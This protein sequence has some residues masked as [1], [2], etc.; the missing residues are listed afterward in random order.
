MKM[1]F[2][3]FVMYQANSRIS[4]EEQETIINSLPND[5]ITQGRTNIPYDSYFSTGTIVENDD[6]ITHSKYIPSSVR[7]KILISQGL[8]S[9]LCI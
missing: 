3:K 4:L 7:N 9:R 2:E 6:I 8:Y 5:S 1:S